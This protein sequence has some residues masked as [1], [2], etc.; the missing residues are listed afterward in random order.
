MDRT[1]TGDDKDGYRW[2]LRAANGRPIAN[3]GDT[4]TSRVGAKV[5]AKRF[6]SA[7]DTASFD[8]EAHK[9]RFVW[10]ATAR[11]GELI[12][13]SARTYRYR[14]F[15][16]L[17]ATR[18]RKA[19][20]NEA[21]AMAG[22]T[23]QGDK[24][25]EQPATW[26]AAGLG[27]VGS[28]IG[29]IGLADADLDRAVINHAS[30]MFVGFLAVFV[31]V[32]LGVFAALLP[33]S[34]KP[35]VVGFGIALFA[36]GVARL[37]WISANFKS[38][39]DRPRISAQFKNGEDGL[40]VVGKVHASGLESDQHVFV[41]IVGVSTDDHLAEFY[42]GHPRREA[43]DKPP[44]RPEKGEESRQAL[45]SSRTGASSDGTAE[46]D[47]DIPVGAGLY[48]RLD[49]EA[50]VSQDTPAEGDEPDVD[51]GLPAVV[52]ADG[53]RQI[54]S[55]RPTKACDRDVEHDM[56]CQSL[57]IPPTLRRPRL[58]AQWKQPVGAQPVLEIVARMGDLSV[59][60]RVL[61]SVRRVSDRKRGGR[62]YAAAWAPDARGVVEEKVAVP[63]GPRTR[64]VCV[65]MRSLRA[66]SAPIVEGDQQFGPCAP[67]RSRGMA[68]QLVAPPKA[69]GSGT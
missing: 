38:A 20:K 44:V 63:V 42:V 37:V 1:V 64:Q 32:V 39:S 28:A 59:D 30:G 52:D 66:A 40:R 29:I 17:A 51:A 25:W 57:M 50:A 36:F 34:Y 7:H 15:A 46:M 24:N 35:W 23:S 11:N 12:G 27:I 21:E 2:E 48:E 49:V 4:F 65:I 61:L 19:L 45:Y 68:V 69:G 31:G 26:L 16:R 67:P 58:S 60:D 54:V 5:G 3:S 33:R 43:G 62:I 22:S 53:E 18:A 9:D 47:F 55:G 10:R 13:E 56:G 14:S 8:V 6:V 41:R